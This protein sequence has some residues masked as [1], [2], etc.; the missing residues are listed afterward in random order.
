MTMLYQSKLQESLKNKLSE[1]I[2]YTIWNL[3][4][5]VIILLEKNLIKSI[6]YIT[7]MKL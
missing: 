2:I 7:N 5:V 1:K 4:Q 3:K 6:E